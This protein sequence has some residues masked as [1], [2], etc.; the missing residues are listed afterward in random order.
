LEDLRRFL[1]TCRGVS[2]K[3]QFGQDHYWM[4]PEEF[5]KSRKGDCD[6]FAMYAWRQLLEMGYKARFGAGTV[7]D[8]LS[9][10]AWATFE[11]GGKHYLLEPQACFLSLRFP[12]LDALRYRPDVSVGWGGEKPHFFFHKKRKFHP[13]ASQAPLLVLEWVCYHVG[14]FLLIAYLLPVGLSK[15]LFGKVLKVKNV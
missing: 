11:K 13:P 2:D 9:K 4:P 6:D 14:V 10:H 3:E 5:E 1:K 7:G 12:R 8:A 15:R